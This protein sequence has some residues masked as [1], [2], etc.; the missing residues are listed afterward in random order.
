M[1]NLAVIMKFIVVSIVLVLLPASCNMSRTFLKPSQIPLVPS[2]TFTTQKDTV[3][4]KV[5]T[6]T[7]QPQF[8]DKNERPLDYDFSIESVLFPNKDGNILNGWMMKPKY[9][10]I[11]GTILH[12]HGSGGNLLFHYSII[13]PLTKYGFQVFSF[14]YSQ[15]GYSEGKANRRSMITDAYAA[16][17]YIEQRA[18]VKDGRLILYG[19]SYGGHLAAIVGS[20]RQ[21]SIDAM[22]IEGA[23]SS[24]REE[25]VHTVPVLGYIVRQGL[26]AKEE[27]K[28]YSKPLLVIHSKEDQSVPIKLG[29]KIYENANEPKAFFEVDKTHIQ[30]LNFYSEEISNRIF[31]MLDNDN[32]R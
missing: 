29:K 13:S 19:Q 24:H 8:F 9:R 16:L 1:N 7:F 30:A 25:A 15:F 26:T 28:K 5:D 21:Q 20:S 32:L 2:F 27:I 23:F 11:A 14:D 3:H 10:D 6:S 4:V 31:K 18:D 22:V 17:S 12:F